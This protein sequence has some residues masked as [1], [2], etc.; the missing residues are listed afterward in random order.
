MHRCAPAAQRA[1]WR[2]ARSAVDCCTANRSSTPRAALVAVTVHARIDGI[3]PAVRQLS[4]PRWYSG[5]GSSLAC[6][7]FASPNSCT[8]RATVKVDHGLGGG[9][10]RLG[11]AAD[12]ANG[13]QRKEVERDEARHGV[14]WN[15]S[16]LWIA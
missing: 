6:S 2:G 8:A 13:R 5:R 1:R 7:G 11:V 12:F 9:Q 15:E 16:A 4:T 3:V 10:V 14:A